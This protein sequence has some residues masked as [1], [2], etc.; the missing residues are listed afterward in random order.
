MTLMLMG[1]KRG[2]VQLFDENG[3]AIPCT[4]IEAQPNV[5]VQIKTK[6][7]DGYDALQMGYDEIVTNDPRTIQKRTTKPRIGHFQKA[8]VT[9]RKFLAESRLEKEGDYTLGQ[10][11]N[12]GA[13]A[14]EAFLD[15]TAVTK[16]KG[17]QGVMKLYNYSGGP[18]SHGSGFHR[19]AGSTGMRSTP[20]RCFPG[21]KRASHMGAERKTIQNVPVFKIVENENLIVVKGQ[22]PGPRNGLVYMK[23]AVK[24]KTVGKKKHSK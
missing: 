10:E 1:K 19:H 12:V 11:V 13:F 4:V 18:A 23:P 22:I 7:K 6:A 14:E 9:P 3:N 21:G 20:G 2:M 15:V 24:K 16:G 17:Y 8:G 5:I